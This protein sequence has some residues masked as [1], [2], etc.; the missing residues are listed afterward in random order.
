MA[1][2]IRS[3]GSKPGP[4]LPNAATRSHS[5]PLIC[6]APRPSSPSTRL[7]TSCRSRPTARP[8]N[9]IR[10]RWVRRTGP[11]SSSI[12][13]SDQRSPQRSATAAPTRL[14][15]VS[16][17]PAPSTWQITG[18]RPYGTWPTGYSV[19]DLPCVA[20]RIFLNGCRGPVDRSRHPAPRIRHSPSLPA[21]LS[22]HLSG[23]QT[24]CI[25]PAS[26]PPYSTTTNP[27][28]DESGRKVPFCF[29][30]H[31]HSAVVLV[32]GAAE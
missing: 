31:Q 24:G 1:P 2:T 18:A 27:K 26:S 9:A 6:I 21:R 7:S 15:R 5:L 20:H 11:C 30:W 28:L 3:H 14:A 10:R 8:T 32:S 23:L 22:K 25:R 16:S 19:N 4:S 29:S 13:S 17:D 12:R